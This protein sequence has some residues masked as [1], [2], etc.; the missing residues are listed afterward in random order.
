M[1]INLIKD[2]YQVDRSGEFQLLNYDGRGIV[3]PQGL[4][5]MGVHSNDRLSIKGET[6]QTPLE[7]RTALENVLRE[8]EMT[9]LFAGMIPLRRNV[10]NQTS[11]SL[12]H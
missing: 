7:A 11:D 6:E 12:N 9:G 4:G 1:A 10:N 8:I 3:V 2:R 5:F